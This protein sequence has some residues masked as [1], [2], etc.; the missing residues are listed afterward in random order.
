MEKNNQ[1]MILIRNGIAL[2]LL[3]VVVLFFRWNCLSEGGSRFAG[4]EEETTV[5]VK[6]FIEEIPK[7]M[8]GVDVN[9]KSYT[10]GVIVGF[11]DKIF[12]L[13]DYASIKEANELKV[14]FTDGSVYS[15]A[16]EEVDVESGVGILSVLKSDVDLDT[17]TVL[18]KVEFGNSDSLNP[19]D[20]I[21]AIGN[22][23]LY[24]KVTDVSQARQVMDAQYKIIQTDLLYNGQGTAFLLTPG[25]KVVGM[26]DTTNKT[27]AYG[28]TDIIN[29]I[30][31][32]CNGTDITYLGIYGD[33][34]EDGSEG[35][36]LTDVKENSPA[37]KAGIR[38]DD[39]IHYVASKKVTTMKDIQSE[40]EKKNID[41]EI[42]LE[43]KNL[44][45][46]T[47]VLGGR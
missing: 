34:P 17:R 1:R 16:V 44:G 7:Y 39:V 19:D 24:G 35:V 40:L 12:I 3:F 30:N 41:E 38:K 18:T 29:I 15:A 2:I 32:I 22:E 5:T 31:H 27:Q 28:M 43:T 26:L 8:V 14:T 9:G 13:C 47:I 6:D 21:A 36:V 25:G 42:I 10:T 20:E 46:I 23:V 4:T 37:W 11:A 33:S 45:E